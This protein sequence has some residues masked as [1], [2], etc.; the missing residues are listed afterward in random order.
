M[1]KEAFWLGVIIV[2]I[3]I[4]L[5]SYIFFGRIRLMWFLRLSY[6][7]ATM[8]LLLGLGVLIVRSKGM[9]RS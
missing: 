8:L 9:N 4:I 5:I 3:G 1:Q 6:H 2:I 7:E